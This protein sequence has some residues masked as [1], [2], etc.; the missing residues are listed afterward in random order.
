MR[1]EQCWQVLKGMGDRLQSRYGYFPH[2]GQHFAI[3]GIC[4]KPQCLQ[5]TGSIGLAH[6]EQYRSAAGTIAPQPRQVWM[7]AGEAW[8]GAGAV[9]GVRV[10]FTGAGIIAT[11]GVKA[12]AGRR[13][14][15]CFLPHCGHSGKWAG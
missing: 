2:F 11:G 8:V 5:V 3:L 9:A 4:L 14:G 12:I 1:C 7:T 15:A 10:L 13:N 6:F